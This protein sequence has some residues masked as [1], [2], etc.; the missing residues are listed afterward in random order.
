MCGVL[1]YIYT[2]F[3][4]KECSF[5]FNLIYLEVLDVDSLKCFEYFIYLQPL[6]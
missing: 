2:L 4:D 5:L 3:E 1:I 6:G